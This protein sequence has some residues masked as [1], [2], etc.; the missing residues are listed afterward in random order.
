[1]LNRVDKADGHGSYY[2]YPAN[3]ERG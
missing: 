3:E 1:V 2:G